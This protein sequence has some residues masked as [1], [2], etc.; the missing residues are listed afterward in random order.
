MI[1][2]FRSRAAAAA[3]A[4][5]ALGASGAAI[6]APSVPAA[7]KGVVEPITGLAPVPVSPLEAVAITELYAQQAPPLP[8]GV[9]ALVQPT[10]SAAS[11]EGEEHPIGTGCEAQFHHGDE[12]RNLNGT[13]EPWEETPHKNETC[14]IIASPW[15]NGHIEERTERV[16]QVLSDKYGGLYDR[17]V[18]RTYTRRVARET[19]SAGGHHHDVCADTGE[20]IT[21]EQWQTGVD[22][23]LATRN[24]LDQYKNNP[25]LLRQHGYWPYPVP[26]TKTFHWFNSGLATETANGTNYYGDREPDGSP[27]VIDPEAQEMFTMALTDDGYVADNVAYVYIYEGEADPFS[28]DANAPGQRPGAD[29]NNEGLGCLLMW[30]GHTQGAE[31]AATFNTDGRTWMAHLWFYGGLYPFGDADLD[32]SE[33]HGWFTPLNLAPPACN[34][35]GGCI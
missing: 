29:G 11:S 21:W 22:L 30:H 6:A 26:G 27:R 9:A 7:S 5:V 24:F 20:Q 25:V 4:L 19:S 18:G 3:A 14:K 31:G 28:I 34:N 23:V 17:E 2:S 16:D 33:P 1:R 15:S 8:A 13:I 12:D 35:G 32:G 10:S